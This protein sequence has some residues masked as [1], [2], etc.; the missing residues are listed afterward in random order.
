MELE[1]V[2]AV[3]IQ[4]RPEFEPAWA[5][6]KLAL[7]DEAEARLGVKQAKADESGAWDALVQAQIALVQAGQGPEEEQALAVMRQRRADYELSSDDL[8]RA[9]VAECRARAVI[10]QAAA[11]FKQEWAALHRVAYGRRA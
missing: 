5:V 3:L 7:A 11:R 2:M 9:E 1:Q 4:R 6:L 10:A 8:C